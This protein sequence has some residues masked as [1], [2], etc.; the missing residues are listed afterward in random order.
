MPRKIRIATVCQN[1]EVGPSADANRDRL[2][3][4]AETLVGSRPDLICLPETFT[5]PFEQGSL[6][7]LAE[8]ITGPTIEACARLAQRAH[9]YVICPLFLRDGDRFFNSAVILDREGVPLGRYDKAH[10]VTS[11]HDFRI[12]ENGAHP[13]PEDIPVF[14]LDFGR[15]G[16]QICFDLI[17]PEG[18][19]RLREKDAEILFW[20]S[21]YDG[22]RELSHQAF[23]LKRPVVSASRGHRSRIIDPMGEILAKT[24][25]SQHTAIATIDLDRVICHLD[26]HPAAAD[27]LRSTYGDRVTVGAH[28]EEA[29]LFVESNDPDL[30]V[31]TL[32]ERHGLEPLEA[33]RDRHRK[34]YA[35]LHAK[36]E[37]ETQIPPYRDRRQHR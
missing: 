1:Y 19:D 23:R 13:G 37:P 18:W 6:E 34:A 31:S 16:I 15:V 25:E 22:G 32:V 27:E 28:Q 24:C 30:P 14:D 5:W 20:P 21:A 9:A 7:Q 2:L 11:S 26:F 29:L 4:K 12:L 3:R 17:F 10:P 33:Y 36:R 8:P 35:A